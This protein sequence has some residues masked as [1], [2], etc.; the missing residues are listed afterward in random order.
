MAEYLNWGIL[1]TGNIAAQFAEGVAGA[2]RSRMAAVGSRRLQ[3]AQAFAERHAIPTAHGDYES[4]V[5]DPQ[6]DAVY[7]GL[8][9]HMHLEWTLRALEAGKHVL[10]EKPLA[11]NTAEAERM[12]DA[13]EKHGRLLV[14]AFMYRSH[15]QTHALLD[16]IRRETIGPLRMIRASFSYSTRN[17]ENNIRFNAAMAG[18]ALMDIGCYC[19]D[20]CNLFAGAEPVAVHATGRLHESG[21]DDLAAAALSY[22]SGLVA[23]FTC[24]MAAQTDNTAYLCGSEGYIAIPIPWK[25]KA[26]GRYIVDSMPRPRSDP[27]A[28]PGITRREE[29]QAADR[30]LYALEADDF[31]AAVLDGTPPV[32]TRDQSLAIMRI[33]DTMRQQIGVSTD[34]TFLENPA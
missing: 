11:F 30:P 8:P 3:T 22:P 29:T 7:I 16:E 34:P 9:N 27:N 26:G 18:G 19:I 31:A 32:V 12:F 17:I 24:G 23:S 2:K 20:F 25:P 28:R 13:A 21:V 10:C 15:P 14:E 1:S 33:L 4:L 5:T 6:V